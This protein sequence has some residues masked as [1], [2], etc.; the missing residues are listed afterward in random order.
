MVHDKERGRSVDAVVD[1]NRRGLLL[2]LT[3]SASNAGDRLM[4]LRVKDGLLL[5]LRRIVVVQW[6]GRVLLLKGTIVKDGGPISAG[7]HRLHLRV[8]GDGHG[9]QR[10]RLLLSC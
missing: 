10:L 5:L 1:Q 4:V 7:G 8:Q 9:R 3:M 6:N 2:L